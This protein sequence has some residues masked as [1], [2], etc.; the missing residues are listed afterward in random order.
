MNCENDTK[1]VD[2]ATILLYDVGINQ[3][4]EGTVMT[5]Y[6]KIARMKPEQK[7]HWIDIP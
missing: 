5:M 4:Q 2:F 6:D 1:T 7:N 3:I